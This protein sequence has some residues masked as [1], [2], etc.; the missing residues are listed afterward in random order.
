RAPQESCMVRL[1]PPS[2]L[3][4]MIRVTAIGYLVF[5]VPNLVLAATHHIDTL[6]PLLARLFDWGGNADS[7]AVMLS[8][9]Y[10]IWAIFL[11]RSA[12]E[13]LG[14]GPLLPFHPTATR[15]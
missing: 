12:G 7:T 8:T 9:V 14:H 6:P 3:P 10:V 5:F 1:R 2:L 13:P 11:L 4:L 15:R